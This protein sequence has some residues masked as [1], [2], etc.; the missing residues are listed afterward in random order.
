MKEEHRDALEESIRK[1]P[2]DIRSYIEKRIELLVMELSGEFSSLLS[3]SV[4]K[5]VGAIFLSLALILLLFSL[6]IFLGEVFHNQSLG[7]LVTSLPILI[8]GLLFV[9]LRPKFMFRRTK[10][11]IYTAMLKSASNISGEQSKDK[12]QAEKKQLTE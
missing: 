4:Y 2:R 8:I 5:S 3:Q 12:E 6:S 1:L 9:S 11:K 7:Y 10:K